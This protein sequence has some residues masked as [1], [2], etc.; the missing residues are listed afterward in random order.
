M[1]T[2]ADIV[3]LAYK[4][5]EESRI[6]DTLGRGRVKVDKRVIDHDSLLLRKSEI[7]ELVSRFTTASGEQSSASAIDRILETI[8]ETANR[9]LDKR[10]HMPVSW[11]RAMMEPRTWYS[12][13]LKDHG[14]RCRLIIQKGLLLLVTDSAKGHD[15]AVLGSRELSRATER[16]NLVVLDGELMGSKT[17]PRSVDCA[18][19]AS[20]CLCYDSD[21]SV[22]SRPFTARHKLAASVVRRLQ[23]SHG[24][25][26]TPSFSIMAK[27]V[28]NSE[29]SFVDAMR[30]GSFL[31]PSNDS[32][33]WSQNRSVTAV[34]GI[35]IYKTLAR[36]G[37]PGSLMKL[38]LH[39]DMTIDLEAQPGIDKDTVSLMAAASGK[40]KVVFTSTRR[41]SQKMILVS[42]AIYEFT[43]DSG[44][45]EFVA[46]RERQ[47]KKDGR[48]N[49]LNVAVDTLADRACDYSRHDFSVFYDF[50]LQ[51]ASSRRF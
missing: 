45:G 2:D 41:S 44:L 20:T 49:G 16:W 32:L 22:N 12:Y 11:R 24:R 30:S 6:R 38:K 8:R 23:P 1:F 27:P 21:V 47:D 31:S 15:I 33:T 7:V 46:V 26:E 51:F 17:S 36:S 35:M 18:F 48:P 37:E 29:K 4:G 39:R 3:D 25:P 28:W 13:A 40:S 19:I 42:G 5:G 10:G 14:V 50:L 43:F 34:D 9:G